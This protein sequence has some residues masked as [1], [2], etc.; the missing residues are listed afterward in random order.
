MEWLSYV[1]IAVIAF[2]F[3]SVI[4]RGVI[5]RKKGKPSCSC[6]GNC[7]ACTLCHASTLDKTDNTDN[8][9]NNNN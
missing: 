3:V 1:L 4:V 7:G 6:G 9:N 2:A 8:T 5:N